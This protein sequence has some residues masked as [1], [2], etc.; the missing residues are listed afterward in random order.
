MTTSALPTTGAPDAT[1]TA[2]PSPT[3]PGKH[4]P[5]KL[6]SSYGGL[7]AIGVLA[8]VMLLWA[9]SSMTAF[10]LG[11]LGKYCSLALAGIGIG[12]AWGRGGM[13]VLGGSLQHLGAQSGPTFD[14]ISIKPNLSVEPGTR[15]ATLPGGRFVMANIPLSAI[16]FTAYELQDA[17][18]V[19]GLPEWV[20]Q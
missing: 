20:Q 14:V 13:L 11:N 10:R 6:L 8:A 7:I 17:F 3:P 12:L 18:Q 5:A 15:V 9:P 4:T 2:A 19:D 1:T 16:V